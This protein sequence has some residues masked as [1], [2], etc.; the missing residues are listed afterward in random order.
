MISTATAFTIPCAKRGS[1]PSQTHALKVNSAMPITAGTNQPATL[2]AILESAR[3]HALRVRDHLDDWE[4]TVSL[5]TRSASM[6]KLPVPLTVPPLTFAWQFSTGIGSPVSI[7]SSTLVLP[8]T[9]RPSTGTFSP[10][11][12][13][14]F[15]RCT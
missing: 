7:D 4:S 14:W 10:G 6:R 12:R 5:P 11:A 3:G 2:S 13:K 8:S 9:T 15:P 1:G